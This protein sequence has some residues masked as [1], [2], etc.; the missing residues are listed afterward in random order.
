MLTEI[1]FLSSTVA[2][3]IKLAHL[4]ISMFEYTRGEY[5]GWGSPINQGLDL[6]LGI[7]MTNAKFRAA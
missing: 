2:H 4:T 1:N 7:A 6:I 3:D 5:Y